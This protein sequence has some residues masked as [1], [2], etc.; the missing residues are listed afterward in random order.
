MVPPRP[1]TNH[2]AR[3]QKFMHILYVDESGS[4]TDI[5]QKYFVLAGISVFE[6]QIHWLTQPLNEIAKRFNPKQSERVELHGS[7]MFTGKRM[8][9]TYPKDMRKKAIMDA[10]KVLAES[11]RSNRIF[12]T[13]VEP[14]AVNE[15][16]IEYAFLQVA[17]RFDHYLARLH[18]MGDSQRG[19][20]L[21]DKSVH[22]QTL[23][24]LAALYRDRGHQWGVLRNLVEV[25]TFIDSRASRLIQLADLVAYAVYRNWCGD[26]QFFQIIES[27]FDFD[28]GKQHGLHVRVGTTSN[29]QP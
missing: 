2:N 26:P 23:Q 14:S 21:F 18:N 4:P 19:V 3:I 12:A 5:R 16:P 11:H 6:R 1:S 24:S 8:W 22:E 20:M 9:R 13:V 28:R 25:P 7:P 17:S 27:R 15:E 10:L 29:S